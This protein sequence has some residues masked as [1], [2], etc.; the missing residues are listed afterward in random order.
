MSLSEQQVTQIA[1]LARLSLSAAELQDNT[2][3]LNAIL[4]LAE[5]LGTI[6]TDGIEPMAHPLHMTQR[7]RADVVSEHDQSDLFQSIAPK[8][9]N[10]HYLVPTVIE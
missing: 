10:K 6:N 5:Q 9:G 7:L 2:K 8:T 1:Y 4:G 3:D